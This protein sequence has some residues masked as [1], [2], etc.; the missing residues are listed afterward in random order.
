M[1]NRFKDR[2][3][4]NKLAHHVIVTMD[5]AMK[6]LK[7]QSQFWDGKESFKQ[8]PYILYGKVEVQKEDLFFDITDNILY[9][10]LYSL[11]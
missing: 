8:C 6:K 5:D 11:T 4:V 7:D 9:S 3:I 2:A 1:L 10:I